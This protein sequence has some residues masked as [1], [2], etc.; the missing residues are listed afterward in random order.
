MKQAFEQL[1]LSNAQKAQIQQIRANTS[2]GK[3]RR[4]QIMAVL[5]PDQKAKLVSLIKAR[6]AAAADSAQ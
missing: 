4:H 1:D 3:D 2:R 5:T 6:K